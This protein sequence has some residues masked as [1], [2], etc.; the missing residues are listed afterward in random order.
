MLSTPSRS[1][2]KCT[3]FLTSENKPYTFKLENLTQPITAATTDSVT[4]DRITISMTK[5]YKLVWTKLTTRERKLKLREFDDDEPIRD[6]Q[7]PLKNIFGM[8][9]QLYSMGD[10]DMKQHIQQAWAKAEDKYKHS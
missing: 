5:Q 3:T 10:T 2:S 9:K 6:E 8:M 7:D 1:T 4:S